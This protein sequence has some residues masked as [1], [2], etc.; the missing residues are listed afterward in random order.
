VT[1]DE[2]FAE[3]EADGKIERHD[4]GNE[5]LKTVPLLSKYWK[6]YLIERKELRKQEVIFK[7][8][9]L[10]KAEFFTLGAHEG[11]PKDWRLPAQGRVAKNEVEKY[12]EVDVHVVTQALK[13]AEQKDKVELLEAIINSIKGRTW[14]I[15]KKLKFLLWSEGAK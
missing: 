1:L 14:D 8:I 15:D 7:K 4:L 11:T 9:R 3:W 13:L 10:D 6:W 2:L 12:L 5:A